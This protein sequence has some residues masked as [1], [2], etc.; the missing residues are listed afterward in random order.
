MAFRTLKS[1][2]PALLALVVLVLLA[3]LPA[4]AQ[5]WAGR[6]R[7]QGEVTDQQGKPVEGAKVTLRVGSGPI[8]PKADGPAVITTNSKGKWS[9][10][11]LTG[12]PWRVLIEKDGF[13]P[14]EGQVSVSEFG[15]AQPIKVTLNPANAAPKQE[16][17]EKAPDKGA[18]ARAN[19]ERGNELLKAGKYTEAREAYE[20]GLVD[21]PAENQ[22]MVLRAIAST[23]YQEKKVEPAIDTLKKALAIAPD[24]ADSL[25]LIINLLVDSGR[26]KEAQA[27]MAKL[28][29]GTAVD[30][31]TLLNIGIK[32]YNEKKF[33]EAVEQFSQVVKDN[34]NLA[35]AY[36]YRGLSYLPLGK[37]AEAKSDFQ[38]VLKVD[39]KYPKADE[40]KEFI[41]S[42]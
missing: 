26:E 35:D 33:A 36:Y 29:A 5:Q 42:L 13:Q 4:A 20:K 11:G 19:L 2:A 41:K 24:D 39:P 9:I 6:G 31:T 15:A 12:G 30:P 14:S 17:K 38:Q 32:L 28:P 21:L 25:R 1:T 27:Y 8:D 37:T 34:P 10:L 23:Y 18:D 7:L 16:G 3:S 40:V 22:P